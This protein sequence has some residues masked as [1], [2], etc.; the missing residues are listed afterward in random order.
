MRKLVIRKI[1]RINK[2]LRTLNVAIFVSI[3]MTIV[4][5]LLYMLL[6]NSVLVLIESLLWLIDGLAYIT[7]L[8]V[9]RIAS[10]RTIYGARYELL[11]AESLGVLAISS[12]AF[13]VIVYL[14]TQTIIEH[15]ANTPI[16]TPIL[17]STFFF[18]EAIASLGV[19]KYISSSLNKSKLKPI[20]MHV[21]SRK[22]LLD[23]IAEAGGGVGII[24][25]NILQN[26]L[27]ELAIIVTIAFYSLMELAKL[28][29][30]STL[31][32]IGIGPR[33]IV[34]ETRIKVIKLVKELHGK[35]P[36]RLFIRTFGT[37]SE[38]EVWLEVPMTMSIGEAYRKATWVAREIIS[39]IPEVLRALVIMIPEEGKEIKKRIKPIR[40]YSKSKLGR[41]NT[42][43]NA[44]RG[45]VNFK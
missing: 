17:A 42:I 35:R 43:T 44:I 12:T 7:I 4:G 9:L 3:A 10:S 41:S 19:R 26:H 2:A 8:V 24:T 40:T 37:F 32:L 11:R 16:I 39:N 33:H 14:V 38:V 1:I 31:Y 18:A 15:I 29:S 13:I 36:K 30:S 23:S 5:L 6:F 25:S 21:T 22:L 45:Q 28:I 27:V 20:I 34:T